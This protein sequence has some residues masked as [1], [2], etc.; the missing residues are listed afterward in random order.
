MFL[1]G[2]E[3]TLELRMN[4]DIEGRAG[5]DHL[6]VANRSETRYVDCSSMPVTYYCDFVADVAERTQRS[7]PQPQVFTVCR[8]ALDAQARANGFSVRRA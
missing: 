4:L 2:T 8:L 1:V 3:G 5:G 7:V 6:F